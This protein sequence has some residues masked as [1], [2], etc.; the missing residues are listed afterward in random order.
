MNC[1]QRLSSSATLLRRSRRQLCTRPRV[2][3]PHH[4][5]TSPPHHPATSPPH[6]PATSPPLHP[7][8]NRTTAPPRHLTTSPP[9]HRS[10]SPPHRRTTASPHHLITAPPHH[11]ITSPPHH[12]TTPPP[13]LPKTN[14]ACCTD[15]APK[16]PPK[17]VPLAS[18]G[19]PKVDAP[20][21][22]V[23]VEVE[24]EQVGASIQLAA[25]V[26]HDSRR[27]KSIAPK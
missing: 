10:T 19:R 1:S 3:P 18:F 14:T 25:P 27:G 16:A 24:I 22:A 7:P 6:H 2:T 11:R 26:Y 12:R 5:T 8:H 23:E 17:A 9:H 21:A 13:V 15:S 4:L 20:A